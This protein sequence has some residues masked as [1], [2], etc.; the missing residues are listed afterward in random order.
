MAWEEALPL[1][2]IRL[3]RTMEINA[4]RN[5]SVLNIRNEK[6]NKNIE[7]VSYKFVKSSI[8]I[9]LILLKSLSYNKF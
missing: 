5:K 3:G 4:G 8:L 6:R 9:S 7:I 1:F 2:E